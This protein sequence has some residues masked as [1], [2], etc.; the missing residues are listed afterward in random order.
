MS[1]T[2]VPL[3]PTR[4]SYVVLLWV[5]IVVAIVAA[6]LLAGFGS[7]IHTT[8]SGLRY[9]VLKPGTG[10]QHP[11]D[12]D[13]A[14]IQFKGSL[15]DGKVFQET[16]QPVPLP[17]AGSIPGFSEG[18]KLMT[19]GAKYRFWIPGD[20]AY[21]AKAGY[22]SPD[23]STVP[24]NAPLKFDVEL[25]DF[26]NRDVLQRQMQMQQ[27]MQ[28]GGMPGGPQGGMPGGAQGGTTPGVGGQ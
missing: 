14:L 6:V 25:V 28:G 19:K 24:N 5:G 10:T 27:M 22:P 16:Q 15:A 4:R 18:L 23:P 26:I 21:N 17:V 1:V 2:A 7:P 20:L 9:E 13:I 3:Q 12:Q 8:E 11:T